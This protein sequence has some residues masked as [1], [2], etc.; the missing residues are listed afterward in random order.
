MSCLHP[1]TRHIRGTPSAVTAA[2][3]Q[4]RGSVNSEQMEPQVLP[5]TGAPELE[6]VLDDDADPQA[7]FSSMYGVV[8][9]CS[10]P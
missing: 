3:V 5:T 4:R 1:S 7:I 2:P 9:A 8:P 10:P 6:A